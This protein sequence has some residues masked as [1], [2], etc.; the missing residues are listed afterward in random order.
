MPPLLTPDGV[1]LLSTAAPLATVLQEARQVHQL[2]AQCSNEL[3]DVNAELKLNIDAREPATAVQRSLQK[4]EAVADKV[5]VVAEKIGVVETGLKGQ[6]RDRRMVDHQFAAAVEQEAAARHLALHDELTG[7]PNRALLTDRLEHELN[8]A[9]RHGWR[10]AVM[11]IDLDGFKLINDRLGHAAGDQVLRVVAQRLTANTRSVDTVS[12][13]GGDEFVFLLTEVKD[14]AFVAQVAEKLL[15]ALDAPCEL[16]QPRSSPG[17]QVR[18]SI[19]IALFPL[20]ATTADALITT[21]DA[22]MYQAKQSGSG[23]AFAI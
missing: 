12:R 19:G 10:T 20:H 17:P 3:A 13:F 7:L 23:Y 18:A 16:G 6:I 1:I 2:V 11:F 9:K 4:N 22:A 15:T 8:Q 5:A 14:E 21:A